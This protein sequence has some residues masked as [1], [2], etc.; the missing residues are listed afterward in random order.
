MAGDVVVI[1][2]VIAAFSALKAVID[3]E[4]VELYR[5]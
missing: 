3:I 4:G 2:A 5:L 1:S